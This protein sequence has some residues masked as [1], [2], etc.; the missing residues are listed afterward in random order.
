MQPAW[1]TKGA[2][3]AGG[4]GGGFIIECRRGSHQEIAIKNVLDGAQ[5]YEGGGE[6][7]M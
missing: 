4:A 1:N 6:L 5:L 2:E 3:S 7:G